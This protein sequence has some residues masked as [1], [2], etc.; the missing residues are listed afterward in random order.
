[1]LWIEERDKENTFFTNL[2]DLQVDLEFTS[3]SGVCRTGPGFL[4][5]PSVT[6]KPRE[7]GRAEL[8]CATN[9]ICLHNLEK[10]VNCAWTLYLKG[11]NI[12]AGPAAVIEQRCCLTFK[13]NLRRNNFAS[14]N[15]RLG[16][17]RPG[18]Y[19]DRRKK[20]NS[21]ILFGKIFHQ[22]IFWRL[23]TIKPRSI[24]DRLPDITSCV[25]T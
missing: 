12:G 18:K 11:R 1:M 2:S 9:F 13:V 7:P 5:P 4:S 3:R 6:S 14:E 20:W 23:R 19:F 21:S 16:M 8:Y 15:N 22:N 10:N 24:D 25:C 17:S